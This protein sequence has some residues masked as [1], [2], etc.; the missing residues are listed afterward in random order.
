MSAVASTSRCPVSSSPTAFGWDE[1]HR[2]RAVGADMG[3]DR[4]RV[5][6]RHAEEPPPTVEDLVVVGQKAGDERCHVGVGDSPPATVSLGDSGVASDGYSPSYVY[7]SRPLRSWGSV[8]ARRPSM[9][10]TSSRSLTDP[11]NVTEQVVASPAG[12][13]GDRQLTIEGS[14][15]TDD[16]ADL[17][18]RIAALECHQRPSADAGVDREMVLGPAAAPG[19]PNRGSEL[20][21]RPHRHR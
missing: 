16:D 6:R 7:R 5:P 15:H 12:A 2:S 11:V 3:K 18:A 10:V 4:E 21:H 14:D 20:V 13:L 9:N 8:P 19:V 17:A 1:R